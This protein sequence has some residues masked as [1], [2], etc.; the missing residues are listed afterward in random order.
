MS[1]R[2]IPDGGDFL[3]AAEVAALDPAE[4]TRR[5]TALAPLVRD[6]AAEAERL[7]RPVA[8][9]W[10]AIRCRSVHPRTPHADGPL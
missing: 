4:L 8:A 3:S 10:S 6:S 7:C 1:E 5:T 9:I 2:R